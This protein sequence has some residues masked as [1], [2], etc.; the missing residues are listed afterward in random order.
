MKVLIVSFLLLTIGLACIV[1]ENNFYQY[2]D[3]E[4]VLH[5]SLFLPLGAVL[6]LLAGVGFVFCLAKILMQKS[7][8][9]H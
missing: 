5:E 3:E 7:K 4:G 8:R 9:K 6:I 1:L 2:I